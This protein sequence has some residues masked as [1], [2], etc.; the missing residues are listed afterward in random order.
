VTA[1]SAAASVAAEANPS[2]VSGN[3]EGVADLTAEAVVLVVAGSAGAADEG[4]ERPV[5]RQQKTYGTRA[6][7][8][9]KTIARETEK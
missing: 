8:V 5:R 6:M 4:D 9:R 1:V 3:S 7:N 2:A